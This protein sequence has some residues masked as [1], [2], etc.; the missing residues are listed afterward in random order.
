MK[1]S[2]AFPFLKIKNNNDKYY[3]I[4]HYLQLAAAKY[5]PPPHNKI[6][7]PLPRL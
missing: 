7:L 1:K 3:S 6:A 2:K 5:L 4:P